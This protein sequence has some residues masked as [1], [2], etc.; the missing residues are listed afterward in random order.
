M[1][2]TGLAIKNSTE[3]SRKCCFSTKN[4][5]ALIE[6]GKEEYAEN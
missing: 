3:E 6:S 2:R 1:T 4:W 5:V